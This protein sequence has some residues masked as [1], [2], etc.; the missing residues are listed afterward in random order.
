MSAQQLDVRLALDPARSVVV[1]ACAGSGKTW[2]LVSRLVRLLLAGVRPGQILAITFTRKAAAEMESRLREALA[3]LAQA[4]DVAV[5][6]YLRQRGLDDAEAQ[7]ALPRARGLYEQCLQAD[8]PLTV[9]TFHSWF[10]RLLSAAP[11]DSPLSGRALDESARALFDEAW[12]G[13]S[14]ECLRDE[15]G[16]VAQALLCLFAELGAPNTRKLLRRFLARQAEWQILLDACA[17]G[18]PDPLDAVLADLPAE[19]GASD[20]P[21]H[22]PLTSPAMRGL[23]QGLLRGLE[24]GSETTKKQAALL[25]AAL[26]ETDDE[27]AAILLA[28]VL[29]TKEGTPR[30]LVA[31]GTKKALGEGDLARFESDLVAAQAIAEG[32]REAQAAARNLRINVC[33]LRAGAALLDRLQ[34]L[35]RARR[36]MDFNDLEIEVERLLQDPVTGACIQARLDARYRHILLDEFQDTNPMQWRVLRAWFDAYAGTDAPPPAVFMVGDPKQSIYRFRRAEP[37]LFDAAREYFEAHQS[38][39]VLHTDH[40]RRNAG[41]VV[42]A[43]N[44]VFAEREG[45]RAQTTERAD[46]PGQ[47]E[48]LPLVQAADAALLE[49]ERDGRDPLTEPI[50]IEEDMRRAGEAQLLV[51]RLQAMLGRSLLREADGRERVMEYGDVLILTRSTKQ[52][53]PYEAALR[54]A[55]IPFVSPGR[56]GLLDTLEAQD[57][58]ALLRFLADP[59]DALSLV[60]VLRSPVFDVSDEELLAIFSREAGTHA[61]WGVLRDRAA[62]GEVPWQAIAAALGEWLEMACHLPAHDLLDFIFHRTDWLTRYRRRVPEVLW[63]SVQA[64]LDAFIALTLSV[65]AGRYPSLSRLVDALRELSGSEDDDAPDEGLIATDAESRGRVRIM[66]IHGSKGLEAP[67]VWLINAHGR[68]RG[69]EAYEM[70]IDWPPEASAPAHFS[71]IARAVELGR[72]RQPLADAEL[73]AQA[74]EQLNL[75]YVAITRAQQVFI[76]SGIELKGADPESH[77]ALLSAALQD[78]AT[79]APLPERAAPVAMSVSEAATM[80]S[81]PARALPRERPALGIG[82][83]RSREPMSEGQQFGVALHAWLERVSAGL[84]APSVSAEVRRAGENVLS[85]P[86][87]AALFDPARILR[88]GN[89]VDWVDVDGQLGRID[90]WVETEEAAWVLDYKSGR[91]DEA[92]MAEYRAQMAGYRRALQPF[93]AGKPIRCLLVF[94]DGQAIEVEA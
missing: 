31:A 67:V 10:A 93:V 81:A 38:A 43:V 28:A 73:A 62:A 5:L 76:A 65:D 3:L 47:V 89:E 69:L 74:R 42:A 36:V 34:S 61:G 54:A 64:N 56:G 78:G 48:I 83:R 59:A 71:V 91:T 58:L 90:R 24:A 25:R 52:L 27:R 11:L 21:P 87:L 26:A 23:L 33:A 77:H 94:S 32:F 15:Q 57:I 18:A 16:A 55:G 72:A 92:P 51:S 29:L 9:G 63:P 39:V 30:K 14:A 68:K 70:L 35:K 79:G 44:A 12:A 66:T 6:D 49:A 22:A 8:P 40:T 19:L 86:A 60:V 84:P 37:R 80:P 50:E 53:A 4:E 17:D 82:E 88:G 7:A 1:E 45:F 41:A 75:L 46:W 85:R 13:L 20:G 2:L